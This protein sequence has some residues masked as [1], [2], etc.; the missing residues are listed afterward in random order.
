MKGYVQESTQ[1]LPEAFVSRKIGG[2]LVDHT[3]RSDMISA[4]RLL[5]S[6]VADIISSLMDKNHIQIHP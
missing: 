6:L 5:R 4:T 3:I 1:Y 2:S